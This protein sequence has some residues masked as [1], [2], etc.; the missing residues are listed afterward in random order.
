MKISYLN[1]IIP[2]SKNNSNIE[3]KRL[4][5]PIQKDIC[6]IN[7]KGLRKNDFSGLDLMI[8]ELFKAP[9]EKFTNKNDF[10]LWTKNKIQEILNQEFKARTSEATAQRKATVNDWYS[11]LSDSNGAYFENKPLQL[12]ILSSITSGLKENNDKTP[13]VLNGGALANTITFMEE[14]LSKNPKEKLSFLKIYNSKLQEMYASISYESYT[15]KGV[16]VAIPSYEHDKENFNSN[17]DKLKALSHPNWCTASTQAEPYL[18]KGDFHIYIVDGK[19]KVGIRMVGDKIAEIQGQ[20]NN[21]QIPLL[22]SEEIRRYA[23]ENNIEG[24]EKNIQTAVDTAKKYAP[25]KEELRQLK[26]RKDYLAI[27]N[28]PEFNCEAQ[29][30]DSGYLKI[31]RF[32][33]HDLEYFGINPNELM[34]MVEVVDGDFDLNTTNIT[35]FK[36]LKV[37]NG[38]LD[39]SNSLM[40]TTGSLER[41][42]GE[43]KLDS[44]KTEIGDNLVEAEKGIYD[45]S[46]P[47][48]IN[49]YLAAVVLLNKISNAKSKKEIFKALGIK[50]KELED[51]TLKIASYN[52]NELESFALL[53]S[54]TEDPFSAI[55]IDEED[56]LDGVSIIVGDLNLQNTNITTIKTVKKIGGDVILENSN[57]KSLGSIEGVRG[58]VYAHNSKLKSLGNL[59]VIGGDGD[60]SDTEITSTRHLKKVGGNLNLKNTN[61]KKINYLTG[62]NLGGK[63]YIDS[64]LFPILDENLN[65]LGLEDKTIIE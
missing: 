21:S 57:L 63:L 62:E 47:D 65:R 22:Y 24:L 64:Y 19:P 13:P 9:I 55:G 28:H 27:F 39:L 25:L 38:N 42:K 61:V 1:N 7:F 20:R 54:Y 18:E 11:Y 46:E 4:Y 43:L 14:E 50:T 12:L 48:G 36:N 3:Q 16:W 58:N 40:E 44:T 37:I 33:S 26:E 53:R 29:M 32:I 2:N 49:N 34:D 51:G 10:N 6:D 35:R 60:F 8:V 17:V 59:I 23:Q 41:V 5:S 15:G 52:P 30:L 56:L 45:T 31:K